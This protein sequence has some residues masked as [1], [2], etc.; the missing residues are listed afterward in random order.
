MHWHGVYLAL[1]TRKFLPVYIWS[2]PLDQGLCNY[3]YTLDSHSKSFVTA[4][5]I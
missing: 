1:K 5:A 2:W 4:G 3:L